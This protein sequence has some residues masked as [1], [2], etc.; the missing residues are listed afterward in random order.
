MFLT[1]SSSFKLLQNVTP[2]SLADTTRSIPVKHNSKNELP[3]GL[4]KTI[5]LVFKRFTIMW[6]SLDQQ[7]KCSNATEMY[8]SVFLVQGISCHRQT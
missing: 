6:L 5:S 8:V 1:C 2:K 3:N 4:Q 7:R